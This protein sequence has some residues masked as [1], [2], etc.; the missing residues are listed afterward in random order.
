MRIVEVDPDGLWEDRAE[1]LRDKLQ[2]PDATVLSQSETVSADNYL[3]ILPPLGI[4]DFYNYFYGTHEY[5]HAIL[6]YYYKMRWGGGG[7]G[8]GGMTRLKADMFYH[9]LNS[10]L[11]VAPWVSLPKG[12]YLHLT[13]NDRSDFANAQADLSLHQMHRL[14]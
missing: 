2:L 14:I 12:P 7:G 13:R 11:C 8:R 5:N 10:L 1:I 4:P 3:S 6:E 9:G